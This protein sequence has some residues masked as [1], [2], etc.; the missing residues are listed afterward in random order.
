MGANVEVRYCVTPHCLNVALHSRLICGTCKNRLYRQR[1]PLRASYIVHKSNAK[2]REISCT[3]TLED[4]KEFCD[5]TNYLN[6]RGKEVGCFVIDRIRHWEGYHKNN[7]QILSV[8]ANAAKSVREKR[9]KFLHYRFQTK[10]EAG[11]PF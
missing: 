10:E 3:L 7:I 8:Q 6:L 4:W 5:R 11:T 1:N 2:Y 9:E